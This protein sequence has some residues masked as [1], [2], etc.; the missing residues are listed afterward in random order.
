MDKEN[1]FEKYIAN[2]HEG[3]FVRGAMWATMLSLPLWLSLFG[4]IK[5]I[6][7]WI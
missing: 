7:S 2:E 5:L 3:N 6:G 1:E 4:W